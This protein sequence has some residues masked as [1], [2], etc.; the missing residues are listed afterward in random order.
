MSEET[1]CS[2]I[3]LNPENSS[4]MTYDDFFFHMFFSKLVITLTASPTTLQAKVV[5]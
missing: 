4:K 1:T 5:E 3:D 2:L